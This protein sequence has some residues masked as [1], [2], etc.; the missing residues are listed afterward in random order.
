MI[1]TTTWGEDKY[2][3]GMNGT[4]KNF[5]TSMDPLIIPSGSFVV[6]FHSDGSNHDWGFKLI[7]LK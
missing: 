2:T 4:A 3:G 1:H 7:S 5:P 6:H